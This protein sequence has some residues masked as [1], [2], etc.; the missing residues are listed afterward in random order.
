MRRGLKG[1]LIAIG[2]ILICAALGLAVRTWG[3]GLVR[4]SGTSMNDTLR[5]GDIV[6]VTRWDYLGSGAPKFADVVECRFSGREATYVKRV[7]GLPG[8][9]VRIEDGEL[10]INGVRVSEPYVSSP[11]EDWA[12]E[13]D[14]DEYLLLGDNRADSYDSR[15]DDMG[16]V[17]RKDLLGRARLIVW[18]VDRIGIIY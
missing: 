1:W 15:M 3:F 9:E 11:T 16:P 12:I 6:L 2:V 13:L 14:G 8:D 5:S 17:H 18:P 10:I 7:C 4:I